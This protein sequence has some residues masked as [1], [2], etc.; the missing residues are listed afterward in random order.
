MATETLKKVA[1]N[2]KLENGTDSEGNLKLV[3]LSLGTLSKDSFDADKA[4]GIVQVLG[5]CLS[6]TINSVVKV[7]TSTISAY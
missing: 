4:L 1:V 6:K 3:N 7:Q 2:L 5:P